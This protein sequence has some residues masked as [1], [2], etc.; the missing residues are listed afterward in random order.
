MKS[1]LYILLIVL[2]YWWVTGFLR[3]RRLKTYKSLRHVNDDGTYH[4]YDRDTMRVGRHG[5]DIPRVQAKNFVHGRPQI[6]MGLSDTWACRDWTFDYFK[7][8]HGNTYFES[9]VQ[10]ENTA[11]GIA[12]SDFYHYAKYQRDNFPLYIF[13]EGVDSRPDTKHLVD[14]WTVPEI[15][16]DDWFDQFDDY[17]RPPYRWI[18]MSPKRSGQQMHV[19]PL[20]TSAWNTLLS[21]KKRWIIFKPDAGIGVH[22]D[23]RETGIDWYLHHY[24]EFKHLEHWDFIQHPG[25]TVYIPSGYWH[26]VINLEDCVSVTQNFLPKKDFA[27]NEHLV[28]RE[29]PDLFE[30]ER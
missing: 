20:A 18:I 23:I 13:D 4:K 9:L 16:R 7:R 21:G 28:R 1:I 12:F 30:K 15:F 29:R 26:N 24:D 14:Q 27:K 6:V 11:I 10:G 22:A 19:D 17:I 2:T 5:K 8:H 3:H 25:E